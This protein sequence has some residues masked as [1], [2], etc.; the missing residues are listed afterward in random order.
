[1]AI[2][3]LAGGAAKDILIHIK[4]DDKDFQKAIKNSDASM[5]TFA[6]SMGKYGPMIGAAFAAAATA[7]AGYSVK[8]AMLHEQLSRGFKELASSQGK[9]S[10][11]YLKK[12]QEVA[13]GTV[14]EVEIMQK[15]NQAML[16]GI[17]LDTIVKMMEGAAVI[18]QATG[19]S[20]Q[21]LFESMA[22]G[23]GR[24]SKLYL[25]NLGILFD[26]NKAHEEY[27]ATLGKTASQLTETERTASFSA[28]AMGG[29][30]ERMIAVGGFTE[31]TSTQMAV[32]KTN[33]EDAAAAAGTK[34]LP[35]LESVVGGLNLIIEKSGGAGAAGALAEM[36]A[37][38]IDVAGLFGTQIAR[39]IT[40]NKLKK[41]GIDTEQEL[42]SLLQ[43]QSDQLNDMTDAEFERKIYLMEGFGFAEKASKLE[44]ARVWGLRHILDIEKEITTESEKQVILEEKKV[45]YLAK[46]SQSEAMRARKAGISLG[47]L[48]G[49]SAA[50]AAGEAYTR[51]SGA[52][53]ITR[54]AQ[55]SGV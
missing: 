6:Y 36:I 29:L 13:R 34:L 44:D 4:G 27:A 24:Q 7:A 21:Y 11:E 10:D 45:A 46:Y 39:L 49:T 33:M 19:Q 17:D 53:T 48:S 22:I 54:A 25:D 14:S 52:F 51:T 28:A 26:L 3:G 40:I 23:I 37:A 18:A 15:A 2:G 38:P 12:I 55:K 41:G 5:G 20:T 35:A 30:E 9:V 47:D 32:L 16:L 42:V 8:V 1:M 50:Y 31:N 43:L